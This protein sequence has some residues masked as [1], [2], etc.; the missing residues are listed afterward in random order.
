VLKDRVALLASNAQSDRRFSASESILHNI[1]SC[2][3]APLW[4]DTDVTAVLY[5]DNPQ[6]SAFTIADLNLFIALSNYSAFAIEQTRLAERLLEQR[7]RR[8]RHDRYHSPR[9][10]E[11][12]LESQE[13]GDSSFIAQVRV[14]SVLF[15]DIVGFTTLAE[16][17]APSAVAHLLNGFFGA[18][19]EVIFEHEG[20]LDKFI[21][22]AILASFGAAL[23]QPDH[24][25]RCVRAALAMRQALARLNGGGDQ[26]KLRMRI[27]IN[28]GHATR[29]R[30][31]LSQTPRLY[32]PGGC[33]QHGFEAR[34]RRSATG[35]NR[36][37]RRYLPA[38]QGRDRGASSWVR[39]SARPF[40][41]GR[42]VRGL[43][44]LDPRLWLAASAPSRH[45][46]L[47]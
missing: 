27:A 38:H 34:I 14:I 10:I 16:Q 1:R 30:H 44:T 41:A 25:L 24:A 5:V 21:G 40:R 22:D 4:H 31:W 28:S 2:M 17:L 47:R 19:T 29:R 35:P 36:H 26:P 42:Y 7:R 9:I 37:L 15:A 32:G 23:P 13:D 39:Q 45:R 8:E 6:S 20:T 12:I 43:T 33:S 46:I 3:C 18:M 11:R